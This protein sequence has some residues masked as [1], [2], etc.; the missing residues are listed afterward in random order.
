MQQ[1]LLDAGLAR[2]KISRQHSYIVYTD[3]D[4]RDSFV[5]VNILQEHLAT[6]GRNHYWLVIMLYQS[7]ESPL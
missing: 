6:F 2:K 5:A 3:C 1:L 4:A 7:Y